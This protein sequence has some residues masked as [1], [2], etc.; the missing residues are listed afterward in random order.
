MNFDYNEIEL[1]VDGHFKISPSGIGKFFEMPSVWYRDNFLGENSFTGNTASYL[2]TILHAIA[3]AVAKGESTDREEVEAFLDIIDDPD[4]DK[5][6]IRDHYPEMSS[7]LINQYVLKNMPDRIEEGIYAKVKNGIYVGGTFD[8][9]QGDTL[10]DY[11]SASSKPRTDSM[12]FN[13]KIQLL[14]YAWILKQSGVEINRLRLVYVTRRT[15]TLPS[16]LF[17][18]NH[19]ITGED[20][21]LIEETLNLMADTVIKQW[22]EPSLIPLLYKSMKLKE[23]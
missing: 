7:A 1:P 20:W 15:K 16:R 5:E 23:I 22:E 14:A 13:Y 2:G 17:E 11:K 3:E 18:V 10:I 4:V 8:A 9:V 6:M 12:V 19:M 21:T